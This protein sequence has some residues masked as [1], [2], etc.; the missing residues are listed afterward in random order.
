MYLI[1]LKRL[2]LSPWLTDMKN[3]SLGVIFC[4]WGKSISPAAFCW[5]FHCV[6]FHNMAPQR[7]EGI[8]Q[9]KSAIHFVNCLWLWLF[10]PTRLKGI[11]DYGVFPIWNW[12]ASAAAAPF[13]GCWSETLNWWE[14]VITLENRQ[15]QTTGSEIDSQRSWE[16]STHQGLT[17]P[18]KVLPN[19][20]FNSNY[21]KLLS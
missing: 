10:F 2:F 9:T 17:N 3:V 1:P 21:S 16:Q 5:F 19:K 7:D 11:F 15:H 6:S 14:M 4:V 12:L 18:S 8:Y 20:H 13:L